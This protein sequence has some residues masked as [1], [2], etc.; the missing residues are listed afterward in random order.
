MTVSFFERYF[1]A[2]DG[3]D[4]FSSLDFVAQDVRFVIHWSA[5][6]KTT[7]FTGGREDLRRF[8]EAGQE[9]RGWRHHVL[10]SGRDGDSEFAAG[11]TRYE[12]GRRIGTYM[13]FAQ[14]DDE[15]RMVRYMAAR[16]P[17][18]HFS[19]LE[20]SSAQAPAASRP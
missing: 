9:W 6:G 13:V 2:L 1:A 20:P 10:F 16:T 18:D 5:D 17:V 7:E 8:I 14:L 19:T 15:G 11:E 3:P 4:P 12:D